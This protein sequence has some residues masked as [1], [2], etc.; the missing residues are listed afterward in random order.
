MIR[1]ARLGF[2][3]ASRAFGGDALTWE[4]DGRDWP[5]RDS[6]RFV[7]AGG[8]TWHVQQMGQG[9]VIFLVHGTG[10]STHS[11]RD[12]AP[13]L[14]A[15]FTVVATD[16]PGHGFTQTPGPGGLSLPAMAT[17]LSALLN[18]LDM[19][20]ALVIGHSAGAAILARMCLDD[21]IAPKALISLNG[22]F[23][24]LRG[25][26][27][28][29]FS[30]IAKLL[31]SFSLMPWLFA[32]MAAKPGVVERLIADTGS[33]LDDGGLELYRQLVSNPRHV[34]ATLGMMANW[35]LEP[36][37]RQLGQ[38]EPALVLV[39]GDNDRTI[40]P[41]EAKRIQ[42]L[43]PKAEIVSLPG[44]G[45]L[46]HEERPSEIAEIVGR[47]AADGTRKRRRG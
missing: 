34:G 44:L 47:Y 29:I 42:S 32:R 28:H 8:L 27:A 35:E 2:P 40:S 26:P 18:A 31:T 45:H 30:P 9:P 16:L 15:H 22:A 37:E 1:A 4:R 41:H 19:R 20:P 3:C 39:V 38:L 6:S 13:L 23:L 25:V 33:K 12:L 14:A 43:V 36:I 24:P 46:A 11:W 7:K 21:R 17:A 5:N 10:A